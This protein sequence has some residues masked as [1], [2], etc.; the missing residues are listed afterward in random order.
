MKNAIV[1][2]SLFVCAIN[3]YAYYQPEKGRWLNRDPIEE[4]GEVNISGFLR[5]NSINDV[6]LLGAVEVKKIVELR[7]RRI[8]VKSPAG[9][10]Q[11]WGWTPAQISPNYSVQEAELIMD[12]A[13]CVVKRKP[14]ITFTITIR[15]QQSGKQK[16]TEFARS[17]NTKNAPV[18]VSKYLAKTTL[19]HENKRFNVWKSALISYFERTYENAVANM[20]ACDCDTL[21]AQIQTLLD[22]SMQQW[23]SS[24]ECQNA[25]REQLRIGIDDTH[26]TLRTEYDSFWK[27]VY[28]LYDFD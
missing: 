25:I 22:K 20:T 13:V 17:S 8:R 1:T 28:I 2:L 3:T 7:K 16:W 12:G 27:G 4:Q 6:D 15:S 11:V 24:Q 5:N 19:T 21:D 26:A 10:R 9:I 23:P 18:Y 14:L